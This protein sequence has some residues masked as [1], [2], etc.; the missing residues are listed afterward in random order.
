VEAALQTL[1]EVLSSALIL[2]Y[3]Q[4]RQRLVIDTDESNF[5]IGGMLSQV[6]DGKEQAAEQGR[7]K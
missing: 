2:A 6:Q 7:Q 4:I 5:G 1:N 3:S